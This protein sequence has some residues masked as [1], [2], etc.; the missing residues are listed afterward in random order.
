MTVPY[1]AAFGEGLEAWCGASRTSREAGAMIGSVPGTSLEQMVEDVVADQPDEDRGLK[2]G[3]SAA[4]R[5]LSA[6]LCPPRATHSRSE[7]KTNEP[8]LTR[9]A[10]HVPARGPAGLLRGLRPGLPGTGGREYAVILPTAATQRGERESA[11]PFSAPGR[12]QQ[13]IAAAEPRGSAVL[14]SVSARQEGGLASPRRLSTSRSSSRPR[15]RS[16]LGERDLRAETTCPRRRLCY[17]GRQRYSL[18]S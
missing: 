7:T 18:P 15:P 11:V 4:R 2:E 5:T 8:L 6:I 17:S 13:V 1:D 3:P 9:S 14:D 10:L 12:F 16:G